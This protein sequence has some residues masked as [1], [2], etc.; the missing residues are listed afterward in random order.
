[1]NDTE[2]IEQYLAGELSNEAMQAFELRLQT[3]HSF[4]ETFRLY[5]MIDNEMQSDEDEEK[6]RNELSQ[7]SKKYFGEEGKAKIIP[8]GSVKK[9]R[10]VYVAAAAAC[11]ALLFIWK[12]WQD[13][14]LSDQQLYAQNAIPE[15]LPATVRGTNNDSLLVRATESYNKKD[16]AAAL[17][18]LDSITKLKPGEAQLQ[19]ALGV[20][21]LQT[22][23]FE[24]AIKEFD[25]LAAGQSTSK[26]DAL[27]WKA[28]AYLKQLFK[29]L[30]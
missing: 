23:K 5:Q 24:T 6:L 14:K 20:C 2:Q 9:N 1:L 26:Y 16:Y 8:I 18:F 13:N 7:H 17:P 12:P 10:W 21:Y 25:E 22:G 27:F 4:A 11:L 15:D 28:L 30:A 3:D 29:A 19:L